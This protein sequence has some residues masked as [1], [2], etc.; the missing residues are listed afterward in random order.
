MT[1]AFAIALKIPDN[2][3]FTA[4][5]ALRRLGV[6][7]ARIERSE[8][9]EFENGEPVERLTAR[10]ESDESIFNPNLHRLSAL[11]R[12][13]PRPGEAWIEP[14]A[15]ASDA[16][17]DDKQ[18]RAIAWRLFDK[19]GKPAT[20]E[21]VLRAVERLL[22]NPAIERAVTGDENDRDNPGVRQ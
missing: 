15:R 20:N 8:I 21:V 13:A 3:A 10:I 12:A 16:A 1:R 7:V 6:D 19:S 9:W 4:L 2:A 11:D 18:L 22:C 17:A 14:R 5:V